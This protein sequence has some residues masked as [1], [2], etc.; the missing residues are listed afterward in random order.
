MRARKK[1]PEKGVRNFLGS[2][3]SLYIFSPFS[4]RIIAGFGNR[5]LALP[6]LGKDIR[7]KI[8]ARAQQEGLTR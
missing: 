3:K 6:G 2:Q 4:G 8:G 1:E 5:V 7:C